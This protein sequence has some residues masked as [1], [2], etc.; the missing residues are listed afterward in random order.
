VKER[1]G[2]R[3]RNWRT[4]SPITSGILRLLII[5]SPCEN[6]ETLACEVSDRVQPRSL[7]MVVT[8]GRT[9]CA[10]TR[11]DYEAVKYKQPPNRIINDEK[12]LVP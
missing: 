6:A 2:S 5:I 1:D 8:T 9:E 3:G 11:D 10:Q 7:I 4:P 12:H